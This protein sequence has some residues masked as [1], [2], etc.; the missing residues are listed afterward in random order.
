MPQEDA[1]AWIMKRAGT[2]RKLQKSVIIKGD[3]FNF[4]MTPLTLAEQQAAQKQARS[5]DANDFALQLLVKKAQDE[6]GQPL[7]RADAVSMLRNAA[8]KA[9]V[10]KLLLALIRDEEEEDMPNLD[11]KSPQKAAKG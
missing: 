4:W 11:M 5:D 8:E 10:E 2:D 3:E 1:L 9:E 7:F 6:N